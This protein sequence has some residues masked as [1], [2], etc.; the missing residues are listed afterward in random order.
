LGGFVAKQDRFYFF[1]TQWQDFLTVLCVDS[2]F[3]AK[4]KNIDGV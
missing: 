3:A 2:T 4:F 1:M